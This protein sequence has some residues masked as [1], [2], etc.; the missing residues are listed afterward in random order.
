MK[1][2]FS[3]LLALI[4]VF[5][6]TPVVIINAT[7]LNPESTDAQLIGYGFNVTAGNPLSK[8]NLQYTY[9]ILDTSN[10]ELFNKIHVVDLQET[11]AQNVVAQSAVELAE[12]VGSSYAGGIE[13]NIA[14]VTVDINAQFDKSQTLSNATSERYEM[15]YQRYGNDCHDTEPV[16]G[17][18]SDFAWRNRHDY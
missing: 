3:M 14:V 8:G 11:K 10:P 9:P 1:R 4:M 18:G 7:H 5:T 17:C 12:Y 6:M 15:Y 16:S 2:V 13:G